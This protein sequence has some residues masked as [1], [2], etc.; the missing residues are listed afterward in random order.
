MVLTPVQS[1]LQDCGHPDAQTITISTK[2]LLRGDLKLIK[3]NSHNR[4]SPNI[5]LCL[6]AYSIFAIRPHL[7]ETAAER[8]RSTYLVKIYNKHTSTNSAHSGHSRS[9]THAR[10]LENLMSRSTPRPAQGELHTIL[11]YIHLH[12]TYN[13]IQYNTVSLTMGEQLRL[14]KRRWKSG[15]TSISG[16][17]LVL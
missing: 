7:R 1:K 4:E 16:I 8:V 9:T 11:T 12:T 5:L 10:P 17:G 14:V 15:K 6:L 2:D 13:T 3:P